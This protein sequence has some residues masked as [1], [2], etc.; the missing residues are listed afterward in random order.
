MSFWYWLLIY[1][2]GSVVVG[3]AVGRMLK[4][5]DGWMPDPDFDVE[6]EEWQSKS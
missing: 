3:L 5:S 4:I 6:A 2:V 1:L